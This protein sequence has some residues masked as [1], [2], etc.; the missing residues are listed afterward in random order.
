MLWGIVIFRRTV[1]YRAAEQGNS[2]ILQKV[3]DW[4]K[5]KLTTQEINNKMFLGTDKEGRSA[6]HM[7]AE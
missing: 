3:W 2:E 5:E 6:W 7:A 1:W 4:A